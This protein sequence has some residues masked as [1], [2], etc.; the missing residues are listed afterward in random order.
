MLLINEKNLKKLKNC[1]CVLYSLFTNKNDIL[2]KDLKAKIKLKNLQIFL[3][4][5]SL[6]QFSLQIFTKEFRSMN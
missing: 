2:E 1:Y 3:K 4:Y 6:L 5:L